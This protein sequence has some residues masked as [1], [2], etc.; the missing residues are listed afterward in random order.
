MIFVNPFCKEF[1]IYSIPY[2][3]INKKRNISFFEK[4][5][6]FLK[7]LLTTQNCYDI[8]ALVELRDQQN[9]IFASVLE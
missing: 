2:R 9:K 5:R 4:I 7:Y 1:V 8:I 3:V 6:N